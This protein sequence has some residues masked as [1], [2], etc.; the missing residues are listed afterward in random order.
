[1]WNYFL[2]FFFAFPFHRLCSVQLS[3]LGGI[4]YKLCQ[5]NYENSLRLLF[6]FHNFKAISR[7]LRQDI[8]LLACVQKQV[9]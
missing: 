8:Y 9:D 5:L 7:R 6:D 3:V 4:N 2:D 1:M